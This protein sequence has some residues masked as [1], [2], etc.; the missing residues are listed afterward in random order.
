MST[1]LRAALDYELRND[2]TL[3]AIVGSRIARAG[4]A[5]QTWTGDDFL[6]W[7]FV[8]GVP[9][10]HQ[11]GSA[12][13]ESVRVQIDCYGAN[14]KR[15]ANAVRSLL[16][17]TTGSVGNPADPVTVK[18]ITLD[19]EFDSFDAPSG[20]SAKS[21]QRCTQEYLVWLVR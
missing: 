2:A 7:F 13:L 5:S 15:A 20:G 3:T 18:T 21:I 10:I 16:Q 6:V 14:C 11:G 19:N 4:D 17:L 1:D 9:E 12:Q 8:S